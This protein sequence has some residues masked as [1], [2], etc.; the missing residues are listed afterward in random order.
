M[1]GWPVISTASTWSELTPCNVHLRGLADAVRRGIQRA[2]GTALEFPAISLGEP[3]MRPTSVLHRNLMA[4]ALEELS[5]AKPLDAVVVLTGCDKT[6]PAGRMGIASVDFSAIMLTGGPTLN[7]RFRGRL[8][9]SCTDS[10]RMTEG[11]RADQV[12]TVDFTEFESCL[13]WPAGHCMAMGTAPTIACITGALG[14]QLPGAAALPAVDSRCL[15]LAERTSAHAVRLAEQGITGGS[16]A[17]DL[18]ADVVNILPPHFFEPSSE[19]VRD[20]V[21]RPLE[22]AAPTSAIL[23]YAPVRTGTALDACSIA[24]LARAHGNLNQVKVGSA[25]PGAFLKQNPPLSA[26]VGYAGLQL[27]EALRRGVAGVQPGCSFTELDLQVWSSWPT[28]EKESAI[29]L[30]TR[31]LPYR[32]Y[33]TQNVELVVAAEKLIVQR[34]GIIANA[35]CRAGPCPGHQRDASG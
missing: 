11:L 16:R 33:S 27:P 2:G 13:S 35:H 29:I 20:H 23:H 19:A 30:H 26:L 4:M 10:W 14:M 31:M 24:E 1:D 3:F 28:C 34:R 12:T 7:G 9:G 25:P 5:R 21:S 22:A 15:T 6:A 8:V 18:G 17:V 32:S